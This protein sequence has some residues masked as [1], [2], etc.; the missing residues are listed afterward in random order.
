MGPAAEPVVLLIRNHHNTLLALAR[1]ALGAFASRPPEYFTEPG[2]C[3]L[4]LP[5]RSD[6]LVGACFLSRSRSFAFSRVPGHML[7]LLTSLTRHRIDGTACVVN[8]PFEVQ[9]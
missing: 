2:L 6:G 7:I 5:G 3:R 4:N 9:G 1:Y 8:V